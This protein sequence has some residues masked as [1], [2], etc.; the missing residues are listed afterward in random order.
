MKKLI[1]FLFI[2]NFLIIPMFFVSV[3][4]EDTDYLAYIEVVMT[5]GKLIRNYT[6]TEMTELKTRSEKAIP[7]GISI[8]KDNVGTKATYISSILVSYENAGTSAIELTKEIQVETKQKISFSSGGQVS[9]GLGGNIKKIKAEIA[10]K[11]DVN[12]SKVTEESVKEKKTMK[13]NVDP[14]TKMILYLTGD[15]LV[16]NGCF[17]YYLLFIK[18]FSAAYE[19][20][21]LNTQYERLEQALIN[22][23]FDIDT[24]GKK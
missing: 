1:F 13:I 8:A 14:N 15:L 16:Y 4:A 3:Y 17:S 6:T 20:V 11:A 5:T 23:S 12:Y 24:G 18:Q 7:F 19:F 2:V 10:A 22:E 9:G 21:I